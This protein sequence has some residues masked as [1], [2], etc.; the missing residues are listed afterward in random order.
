M[1]KVRFENALTFLGDRRSSRFKEQASAA[2]QLYLL[3]HFSLTKS[4]TVYKM[5]MVVRGA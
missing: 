4:V 3:L 5:N 1:I 2:E